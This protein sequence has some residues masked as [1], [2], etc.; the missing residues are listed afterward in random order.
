MTVCK[1]CVL[2]DQSVPDI[3]FDRSGLCNYCNNFYEVISK[4]WFPN[5]MGEKKLSKILERIRKEGKNKEYDCII[6]LSG[7]IDSSHL[8]L[9]AKDWNLRPLV[10]HVDAG[11]NSELAVSNIEKIINYT[12]FDLHTEVIDWDVMRRLQLAYL[13]SGLSNQDVPQ[14]HIFY[15]T[16]YKYSIK[17]KINYSIS[18]GNIA[19]ESILP[20]IWH[21]PAM[22]EISLKNVFKK[23]GTGS[24]KKY[25]TI[26]FF[27]YYIWYPFINRLTSI[28]P[29]N[30][31]P[32][33]KESARI[34]LE[35]IGFKNYYGKHGESIFTKFFQ[36][37]YLPI[38][39]NIDKRKAH[40][41]SLILSKQIS[42]EEAIKELQKPSYDKDRIDETIFYICKKLEISKDEFN[43][44]L[45]IP[46]RKYEDYSNWNSKRKILTILHTIFKKVTG[47]KIKL[48]S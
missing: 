21:G 7:G 45:K 47:K 46:N 40:L 24:L 43:D 39:F 44:L 30:F 37:Y 15:S 5:N 18:G 31:M 35:K 26:S 38:K 36:E 9:K 12:G 16:L 11:W 34:E 29:L 27:Q 42:R 23:F 8:T 41:S 33:D 17:H 10:V 13:K 1:N 48:Y 4:E 25:Q 28:R 32:Y 6:G 2:D 22:D 14:D 3:Y 19:T 20:N